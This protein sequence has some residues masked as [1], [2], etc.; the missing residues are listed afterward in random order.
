MVV[1]LQDSG[2]ET[3][4]LVNVRYWANNLK[5][6]MYCIQLTCFSGSREEHFKTR[7]AW[8]MFNTCKVVHWLVCFFHACINTVVQ[9]CHELE[10]ILNGQIIYEPN[11]TS[12]HFIGTTAIYMCNQG[13]GLTENMVRSC[14]A[15]LHNLNASWSGN[16]ASCAGKN[17][18]VDI[19]WF[20]SQMCWFYQASL[21]SFSRYTS[22]SAIY[23]ITWDG[24]TACYN[25]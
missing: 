21:I 11:N 5:I 23:I 1:A 9:P 3:L 8:C 7:G 15:N 12:Y 2:Q 17:Y 4:P 24:W 16:A 20:D 22:G 25:K 6:M 13:F 14:V 18:H 19:L 10:S